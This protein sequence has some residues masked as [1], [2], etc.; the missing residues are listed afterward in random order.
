MRRL[1]LS[2]V[3]ICNLLSVCRL[4][5]LETESDLC[6]C[7]TFV[8]RCCDVPDNSLARTHKQREMHTNAVRKLEQAGFLHSVC[9]W[10]IVPHTLGF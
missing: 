10:K 3:C 7:F 1:F 8:S 9:A 6:V 4:R 2:S 5:R